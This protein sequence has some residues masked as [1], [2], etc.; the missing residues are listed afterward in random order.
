MS[1]ILGRPLEE[2]GERSRRVHVFDTTL[3]DGEQT[4][5]V[6][7]TRE[8]KIEIARQLDRLGVD[9]I[10]VGTPITSEG[11]RD[12]ARAISR[13][14]LSAEI[15]GLARVVRGD[16]DAAIDCDVDRVHVFVSTSDIQMK[17]AINM[18]REDV[19]SATVDSVQHV[20]DRGLACE[21]SPMD[22]TRT[23]LGYLKEVCGAAEEAGADVINIPDTVGIMTPPAM[24]RL[25]GD[26]A[27]AVRT[28]LSVHCHNDFG[29]AAANTLA[30]VE[31]GA[32][33]VE[34]AVNGLGERAG[35]A[36]LEEVAMALRLIYGYETGI[37]TEMI[38]E[39]SQLVSN[40]SGVIIQPNKAIVGENAFAHESGIHTR[41]IAEVPLTFEP[42]DPALVGASRRFV[43]G[44]VS[45]ARGVKTSLEGMHLQP[46]EAQ[47]RE[48]VMRVK[49]LGDMGETV[50]DAD[51]YEIASE[52]MNIRQED[53][54]KLK[55]LLV[56]TGN[57]ITPTASV[58]LL[59]DGR[60][61]I[62]SGIGN[63]PIDSAIN[64]IRQ[65]VQGFADISLERFAMKAMTGGT[66]AVADVTVRLRRGDQR[67]T[68]NGVSGDTVMASVEAILRGM[69]RL[70]DQS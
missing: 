2:R 6:S 59:V 53:R 35:N 40:I 34:V 70:L 66:S 45:G 21:F 36:A 17:H 11:D 27:G 64:A 46:T 4:P 12:V 15:C 60:E 42:I 37:K 55:Q 62:G 23:D 52:V 20:K 48:V 33:Q 19:L 58:T 25:I 10:E 54:V 68:S 32:S 39:T 38:Y 18:T 14:G 26:V 16:I 61:F 43:S 28:P 41:G 31:G 50:T 57:T 49:E 8:E 69:N 13:L 3:R 63:G 5:W 47:L 51:L 29:M 9:V 30:A 67:V 22:A 44:K 56:V 24:K 65:V 1:R 7:F